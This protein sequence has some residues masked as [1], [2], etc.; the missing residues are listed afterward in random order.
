MELKEKLFA[1][2]QGLDDHEVFLDMLKRYT[3]RCSAGVTSGE[4]G[5]YLY[6]CN[7]EFLVK[8]LPKESRTRITEYLPGHVRKCRSCS[9]IYNALE[10][11]YPVDRN[12]SAEEA[13]VWLQ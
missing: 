10:R 8:A 6:V 11:V 9:F 13:K 12:E 2:D 1:D 5:C 3:S 4:L 7:D